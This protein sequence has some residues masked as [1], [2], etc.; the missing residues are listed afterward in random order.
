M[1][2]FGMICLSEEAEH[3]PTMTRLICEVHHGGLNG[4]LKF[5][6]PEGGGRPEIKR[7]MRDASQ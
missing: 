3:S 2:C 1:T 7:V 6:A 5:G 4:A